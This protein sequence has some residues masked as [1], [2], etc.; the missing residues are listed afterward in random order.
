MRGRVLLAGG[1]AA[2]LLGACDTPDV[3]TYANPY[4][5]QQPGGPTALDRPSGPRLQA[6]TTTSATIVWDDRSQAEQGYRVERS[7]DGDA[8]ATVATLPPNSTTFTDTALVGTRP[9]AYRLRTLAG[10]TLSTP[11]DS[12][13]LVWP[14]LSRAPVANPVSVLVE[15]PTGFLT[16][17]SLLY[18]VSGG[19]HRYDTGETV[20]TLS[21]LQTDRFPN[22]NT[23]GSLAVAPTLDGGAGNVL[24]RTLTLETGQIAAQLSRPSFIIWN[25]YAGF[26][27]EVTVLWTETTYSAI[28]GYATRLG[29]WNTQTGATGSSPVVFAAGS[30]PCLFLPRANTVVACRS[31]NL[32]DTLVAAY[33]ATTGAQRWGR[34]GPAIFSNSTISPDQQELGAGP[35]LSGAG[36][37]LFSTL[38]GQSIGFIPNAAFLPTS[39]G[40][41]SVPYAW[42]VLAFSHNRTQLLLTTSQFL[43][44]FDRARAIPKRVL[45][46]PTSDGY[47]AGIDDALFAP[48]GT[49]LYVA[50]NGSLYRVDL[51]AVWKTE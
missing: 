6:A 25:S 27:D 38:T 32:N 41:R 13:R 36:A 50:T 9:Y 12:L 31:S 37:F 14:G 24:F 10:T 23:S 21:A 46:F 1:V 3:P 28:T 2:L 43:F 18:P 44:V 26:L 29:T 42:W 20:S 22:V 15:L 33:D 34:G 11:S 49:T 35:Y 5:A 8:F 47:Y 4:D 48:N 45:A 30:F 51:T 16:A 17:P 39:A 19:F 7:Y 40:R